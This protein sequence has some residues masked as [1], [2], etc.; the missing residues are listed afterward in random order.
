[1]DGRWGGFIQAGRAEILAWSDYRGRTDFLRFLLNTVNRSNVNKAEVRLLEQAAAGHVAAAR[2]LYERYREVAFRV[3]FRVTGRREDALDVVQDAFI[4]AFERLDQFHG[5]SG[6]QTWLLRIVTN[7]ALDLIRARRVR[8]AVSLDADED[9]NAVPLPAGGKESAP[10]HEIESRELAERLR[11]AIEALPPEQR[12]VFALYATGE[13]TYG[14]I[15]EVL[16]IPIGTVMSRL[17]HARRRLHQMLP[18]LA[19]PDAE[20][21][22]SSGDSPETE[23]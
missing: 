8:Y 6:F 7:R 15:A 9:R 13:M 22:R 16:D 12:A 2:E 17:Y 23:R 4:R 20:T 5:Q 21:Q 1:M 19:P 3:A 10:G 18:D 11:A 14:Q